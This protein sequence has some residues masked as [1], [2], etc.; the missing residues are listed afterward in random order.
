MFQLP[1]EPLAARAGSAVV[2]L[3][4]LAL[5][6]SVQAQAC[7]CTDIA[8]IKKRMKEADVAIKSY[9]EEMQKIA[10]QMQRQ[11]TVLLADRE[12]RA[13]MQSRIQ[14]AL[15]QTAGGLP[16]APTAGDNPGG[17]DNLCNTTINLAPSATA[18]MR[19]SLSRHE[20]FHRQ[21]CLRTRSMAKIG[22]SIATGKDRFERDGTTLVAYATEEIG[23]YTA[24]K[25]FLQ[26]ELSRLQQA[27]ECR[28][29]PI[30]TRD[31]TG[32]ARDRAPSSNRQNPVDSLRRK[33]G[34]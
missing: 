30:E 11:R 19:E 16:T 12:K 15:D 34:F 26:G 4:F 23:G 24:E 5:P 25:A 33:F 6:A 17:T 7:G 28:P 9:A 14:H 10:E 2:L 29:K 27:P 1:N 8:D 20:A 13:K 32:Q 3:S 31:Y 22:E 18:C 21:E